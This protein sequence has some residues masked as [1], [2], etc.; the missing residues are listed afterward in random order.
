MFLEEVDVLV[1]C[2]QS[3]GLQTLPQF[4]QHDDAVMLRRLTVQDVL[5][6]WEGRG[7]REN[8]EIQ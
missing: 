4:L 2:L 3:Q 7:D 5:D 8:S 1:V 6:H